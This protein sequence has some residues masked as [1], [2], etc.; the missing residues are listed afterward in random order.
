MV[1]EELRDGHVGSDDWNDAVAVLEA[2]RRARE[3]ADGSAVQ[4]AGTLPAAALP[5]KIDFE[6]PS[7][8]SV[9]LSNRSKA[10]LCSSRSQPSE[11]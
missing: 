5:T 8:A 7:G 6:H 10:R 2:Q 4:E 9:A 11:R 3:A 1:H